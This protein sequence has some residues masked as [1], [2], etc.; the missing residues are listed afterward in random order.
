MAFSGRRIN[1]GIAALISPLR[2]SLHNARPLTCVSH[3]ELPG[4]CM[5][6][7]LLSHQGLLYQGTVF[8]ILLM[9]AHVNC[10]RS[11]GGHEKFSEDS[12]LI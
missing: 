7:R 5:D 6:L 2:L 9:T 8:C 4:L 3:Y 10:V 12:F 11:S 1:H